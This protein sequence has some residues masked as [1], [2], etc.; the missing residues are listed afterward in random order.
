MNFC[1]YKPYAANKSQ[2]NCLETHYSITNVHFRKIN[3]SNLTYQT[4]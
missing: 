2:V 4:V 3:W 1:V